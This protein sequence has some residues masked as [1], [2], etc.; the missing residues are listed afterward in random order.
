MAI[1]EAIE[2]AERER[3]DIAALLAAPTADTIAASTAGRWNVLETAELDAFRENAGG[4]LPADLEAVL[5]SPAGLTVTAVRDDLNDNALGALHEL[6]ATGWLDASGARIASLRVLEADAR[7]SLTAAASNDLT[8]ARADGFRDLGILLAVLLVVT[9]LGLVLR[10][11]IT[12]PLREVSEGARNLSSG[13]LAFDIGYSGRDEIGHVASAFHD[14]HVTVE[15]LAGEIR[16]IT[17]AVRD[18]RLGHRADVA[19]FEGRWSQLLAG[20]NDTMAAFAD[21]EG[22]RERA[23]RQLGDFFA[24]PRPALHRQPL[25]LLHPCQ[26]GLRANARVL[27]RRTDVATLHRVRSS[28]RPGAHPGGFP[29]AQLG[30]DVSEFETRYL[31]SDGRVRWLQW[32]A[33]AVLAEG[34]VYAVGRDVTERRRSE[35]QQTALRRVATLVAEGA[36]PAETFAAITTEV[37]R[38]LGT[39]HTSLIRVPPDG[40]A[41]VVGA[42]TS[43]GRAPPVP[44]GSRLSPGGRNMATLVLET[45]RPARID[46]YVDTS[47]H[48][49]HIARRW[50]IRASVGVPITVEGRLWGVMNAVSTREQPLP[51]DAEARLADFTELVATAVANAQARLEL[52]GFAAEQAALRRVATLVARA[53][54]PEQVFA[55]VT[56]EVRR[57]LTV[58]LTAMGR[59]DPN[60]TV[61]YVGLEHDGDE[62]A[63]GVRVPLGGQNLVT[64]VCETGRPARI[65]DYSAASGP[66]ADLVRGFGICAGVGVPISVEGRLW[67]AMMAM[68]REQPLP[69]DTE[70]RLADFTELVATALANA[71]NQAQLT[72]SRA[73][74][75]AAADQVRRRIERDLHDGAQ[76]RLVSLGLHLRAAQAAVPPEAIELAARFDGLAD[77]VTTALDELRE[78]ARGIHPA[79]LAQGGLRPALRGWPAAPRSRSHWTYG[80]TGGCPSSSRPPPTMWSPRR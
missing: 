47:G 79:A 69:A 56:T 3:A 59:Y 55:A 10:R 38:V 71:E 61:T 76:Q 15:R 50:G 36:S 42:W 11:S 77:E 20:V 25:R 12:V 66:S 80:S 22:R 34:L 26:P 54:P 23:E 58:D 62:G 49:A 8:A 7:A 18:N 43:T 29:H 41:T 2:A 32:S 14:L 13:K 51:A 1:V 35:D 30:Q 64:L 53:A 28:Q 72:A 16:E 75:V 70:A 39:D 33:R 5:F 45:G 65:D 57:L 68:A 67:G 46:D 17:A 78:L 9:G 21:V 27:E 24:L 19:A 40:E 6:S 74:I 44:V 52:R 4:S 37:G 31:C 60:G 48:A 73:R 63:V